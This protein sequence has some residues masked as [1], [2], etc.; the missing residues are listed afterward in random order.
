M[1]AE[2]L[3]LRIAFTLGALIL[4]RIGTYI[5]LPGIDPFVWDQ[6]FRSHPGGIWAAV[7]SLSG[8]A[9]RRLS[10]FA[11][12]IN[13]FVTAAIL[14]QLSSMAVPAL[15]RPRTQGERGRRSIHRY[16]LG[17]TMAM[18]IFQSYGV[19]VGM[20]RVSNLVAEPGLS[21]RV[22]TVAM[23]TGGTL[24]LI[25]LS[26]QI[27]LRGVGNGLTLILCTAVVTQV[28]SGIA[29]MLELSRQGVVSTG[30]IL[31][32]SAM[33]VAVIFFVV[34]VELTR[35]SIPLEFSDRQDGTARRMSALSLKI[36]SAGVIPFVASSWLLFV[37]LTFVGMLGGPSWL[38]TVIE[39][40]LGPGRGWH[41]IYSFAAIVF[42]AVVYTA[43]LLSPAEVAEKLKQYGGG[44]PGIEPGERTAA[45]VDSVLSRTALLGAVYLA[46]ICLIPEMLTAYAQVPIYLGGVPA[47]IVV[48]TVLDI[49][50]QVR[51]EA[52]A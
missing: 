28:P 52:L 20:E 6:L 51:V 5:P 31:V 18:V 47:L 1:K 37:P 25:W 15:A 13:P 40:L 39:Q 21:F 27:T 49:G 44:I 17:L 35:L 50:Q 14:I 29:S 9:F 33:S 22:S 16:T 12:G 11:L 3:G 41:M 36:N 46:F 45:L 32:V 34:F 19:S 10:I 48:A 2:E 30:F 43:F 24:F 42:L 23:L 26:E 8:G 38:S 7:D 4:Y